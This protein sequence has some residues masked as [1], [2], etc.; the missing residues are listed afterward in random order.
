MYRLIKYTDLVI[1]N[2]K[3]NLLRKCYENSIAELKNLKQSYENKE[4]MRFTNWIEV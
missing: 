2:V 4:S 3:T 1:F